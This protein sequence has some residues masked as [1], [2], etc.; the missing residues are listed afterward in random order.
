MTELIRKTLKDT[1]TEYLL[2][3][4]R[5]VANFNNPVD[6]C[7]DALNYI[8]TKNEDSFIN[9]VLNGV[10]EIDIQSLDAVKSLKRLYKSVQV[11]QKAITNDKIERYKKLTVNGIFYQDKISDS[12]YELYI[13]LID[14]LNDTEFLILY[15]INQLEN[16]HIGETFNAHISEEISKNLLS[17][18][19]MEPDLF[20]SYISR[21]KAKGLI[22]DVHG[23]WI[24]MNTPFYIG[25]VDGKISTF[26]K[27][28]LEFLEM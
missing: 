13:N 21:L 2:K 19:D 5:M 10:N 8:E 11:I 20:A 18:L 6:L 28:L 23:H 27:Q 4:G 26:Y 7:K 9:N 17:D 1:I 12:D 16:K 22:T 14:E 15:K 3:A 24:S 25:I